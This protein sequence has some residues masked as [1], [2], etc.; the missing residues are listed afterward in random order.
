MDRTRKNYGAV[1]LLDQDRAYLLLLLSLLVGE[2]EKLKSEL[3]ETIGIVIV[4]KL[5]IIS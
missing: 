1:G 3:T 5:L 4:Q 2:I